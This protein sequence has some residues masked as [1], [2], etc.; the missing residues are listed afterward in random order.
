[1]VV[2]PLAHPGLKESDDINMRDHEGHTD[3]FGVTAMLVVFMIMMVLLAYRYKK[4]YQ[5]V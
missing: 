4:E 2:H 3:T 1:M 5:M